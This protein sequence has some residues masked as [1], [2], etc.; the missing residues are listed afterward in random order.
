MNFFK[1]IIL[2]LIFSFSLQSCSNTNENRWEIKL[3]TAAPNVEITDISKEFYDQKVPLQE[4]QKKY[5]FFQGTVP[6]EDY[7]LRRADSAEIKLYKEAIAKIDQTKL[8]TDLAL[9]FAHIEHYFPNFETPKVFLFSSALQ[10]AP[11]PIFLEEKSNFLF[12]DITGFM[13]INNPNYQGMELYFQKSMNPQNIV[14]KVSEMLAVQFVPQSGKQ[15]KFLDK[16]IY[17]GKILTLQDAFLPAEPDYLKMNFTAEQYEWADQNEENIW[18]FFVENN[19]VF[20]DD[21]RL[22]E[23][24]IAKGPFSKFYT[25]IDNESSPQVGTYT[26]WQICRKF[27]N[28]KPDT[29]LQEFLNMDAQ[30][31]FSESVYKSKK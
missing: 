3:D 28:E 27:F 8:K 11:D 2:S 19:L 29:K 31:L 15:L 10:M 22:N 14:A 30:T 26:G 18:N 25:E 6:D 20:S 24:F 23:R 7:A 12:I 13:G 1:Y 9:L 17:E 4:F 21:P 16:I 5:D